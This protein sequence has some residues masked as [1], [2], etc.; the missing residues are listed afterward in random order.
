MTNLGP[1]AIELSQLF[2]QLETLSNVQL[3]ETV[4][5][6]NRQSTRDDLEMLNRREA[7]FAARA[8]LAKSEQR[9][10]M[11]IIEM[12]EVISKYMEVLT[13]YYRPR[14]TM[15]VSHDLI[16]GLH[17]YD[18]E[19]VYEPK[20]FPPP[21]PPEFSS[22]SFQ[23]LCT[24]FVASKT[25]LYKRIKRDF[26]YK[27]FGP[28]NTLSYFNEMKSKEIRERVMEAAGSDT[29]FHTAVGLYARDLISTGRYDTLTMAW[30]TQIGKIH[31][32][33]PEI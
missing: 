9:N 26:R 27:P 7:Y 4:H 12:E 5:F 6:Y 33:D 2:L 28:K 25:K 16:S 21:A 23:T 29:F 32:L 8:Y 13:N 14:T 3:D 1:Q 30:R 20:Y 18:L 15:S 31:P 17:S 10:S 11:S 22:H 24:E 19:E